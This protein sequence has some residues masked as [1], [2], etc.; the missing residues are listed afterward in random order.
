MGLAL[1]GAYGPS[2]AAVASATLDD[3]R[4]GLRKLLANLFRWRVGWRWYLFVLFLPP[5][6]LWIG[7]VISVLRG[8]SIGFIRIGGALPSALTLA[9]FIPVGPPGEELGWRGYALSRFD[10]VFNPLLS[11]LVLGMIWAAWHI[12]M[13]WF[14][15][16]GC[17]REILE[18][19]AFAGTATGL[20]I[21]KRLIQAF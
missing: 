5:S 8:D 2:I 20:E 1:F 14:P 12:P 7:A 6:F 10:A 16:V 3:G 21:T 18:D 4:N 19:H 9:T 11:S 15:P 13:F 17:R